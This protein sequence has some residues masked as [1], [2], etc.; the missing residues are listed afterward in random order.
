MHRPH[1]LWLSTF[2]YALPYVLPFTSASHDPHRAMFSVCHKCPLVSISHRNTPSYKSMENPP[3][4]LGQ[5][6]PKNSS[7]KKRHFFP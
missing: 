2:S 7:S 4:H 3:R 1:T 6:I 5:H